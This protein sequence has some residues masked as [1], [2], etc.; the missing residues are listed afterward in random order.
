MSRKTLVCIL[1]SLFLFCLSL[2]GCNGHELGSKRSLSGNQSTLALATLCHAIPLCREFRRSELSVSTSIESDRVS[3]LHAL[4]VA[5]FPTSSAVVC[6]DALAV[7]R[8]TIAM[9]AVDIERCG[10]NSYWYWNTTTNAGACRC[11][12]D[13][14]CSVEAQQLGH[15]LV[16]PIL[17]VATVLFSL[18]VGIFIF[19]RILYSPEARVSSTSSTARV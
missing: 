11:F 2:N 17:V 15:D 8:L 6:E 18:I 13:R 1:C 12:F 4:G 19:M 3:A 14:D 9:L 16:H 5:A 7:A 10:R